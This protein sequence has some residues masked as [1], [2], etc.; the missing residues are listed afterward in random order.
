MPSL[1]KLFVVFARIGGVTFGGGMAM[2]PILQSDIVERYH[3]ATEEELTDYYAVGQCTPGIIGDIVA[4]LGVVF[5]SLVIISILAAGLANL[6][7]YP[8]VKDAFAGIRVCVCILIFNAVSK[9]ARSAIVDWLT[10]GVFLVVLGINL[11]TDVSP[12]ILVIF[13]G[14]VG[15]WGKLGLKK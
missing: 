6:A 15:L 9:L 11:F 14:M 3:W 7:D 10:I 2:L 12:V 5:P 13:A 4:T 8:A 1:W